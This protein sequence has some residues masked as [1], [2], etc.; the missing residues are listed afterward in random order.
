MWSDTQMQC[1]TAGNPRLCTEG[2]RKGLAVFM[3]A[4]SAGGGAW[5]GHR[6]QTEEWRDAPLDHLKVAVRPTRGGG[7]VAVTLDF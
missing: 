1:G 7:R 3:V 2:E 5:W 6:K 4:L